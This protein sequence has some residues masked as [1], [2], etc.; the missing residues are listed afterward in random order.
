MY[1]F[2]PSTSKSESH[3]IET[4]D[5]RLPGREGEGE[6]QAVVGGRERSRPARARLHVGG[7]LYDLSRVRDD[8][9]QVCAG[10]RRGTVVWECGR[11]S[12]KDEKKY[13]S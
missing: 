4:W 12:K 11:C 7:Q 1:T 13:G 8:D 5:A 10:E 2:A 9:D 6:T 3:G